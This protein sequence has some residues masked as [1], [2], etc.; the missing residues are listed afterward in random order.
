MSD[1]AR[2]ASTAFAAKPAQVPYA[3]FSISPQK[4]VEIGN[5]VSTAIEDSAYA[6][7]VSY[8]EAVSYIPK[9]SIAWSVVRLYYSCF[10]SIRALLLMN[11]MLPFNCKGEMY[12]DVNSGSFLKGGS[13]SHHFN[14]MAIRKHLSVS[15]NWFISEDSQVAYEK[16][17][18]F[19]ESINYTHGFTDPEYHDCLSAGSDGFEKRL[20][21]YRDDEQFLY[22]Y[23][24]DHLA[25]S[26]PTKLIFHLDG[27]L[28]TRSNRL[29]PKRAAH[30]RSV[31]KLKDR[32]PLS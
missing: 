10:Y 5:G 30:I 26:Y 8:V 2:L 14:W 11:G 18:T 27:E 12:L 13:S 3:N 20:R 1:S 24:V 22:T 28:D 7:A 19:R 15:A 16:L 32:C 29:S 4:L 17:R 25:L 23:L 31:W 21:S 9:G 6:A